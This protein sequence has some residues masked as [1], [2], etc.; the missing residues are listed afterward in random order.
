MYEWATLREQVWQAARSAR[1]DGLVTGASGNFSTLA[2]DGERFA[3]T[4]TALR[5]ET[6]TVEDIVIVALDGA[7]VDG[8]RRPSSEWR[9]HSAIYRRMPKVR[10]VAHTHAPYASS[11]AVLNESIPPVLIEMVLLGGEVPVA[12]FA[13]PGTDA[14]GIGVAEAL[15]ASG[16]AA[17]LLQSHGAVTVGATMEEAYVRSLYLEDAARIYH[18]ARTVGEPRSVAAE[19]FAALGSGDKPDSGRRSAVH[20]ERVRNSLA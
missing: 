5:Y 9:L 19:A 20:T 4:P 18:L 12:P 1:S 10:S 8:A 6:M 14:L 13:L 7:V 15:V 16:C 2:A 17:C 11:F 3:I